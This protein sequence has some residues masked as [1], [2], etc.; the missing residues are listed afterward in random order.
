M[1][2]DVDVAVAELTQSVA[3]W[4]HVGAPHEAAVARTVLGDAHDRA[5]NDPCATLE[6]Q[7]AR[8]EFERLGSRLWLDAVETRL[9][10][11]AHP[12]ATDDLDHVAQPEDTGAN[13]FRCDGDVR[14]VTFDNE[15]V[16]LRDLKGMHYIARP[17]AEPDRELH[18]LDLV[19]AEEGAIPADVAGEDF[20]AVT[21]GGDAGFVLDDQARAAY[22]RRLDE[23]ERDIDEA[24]RMNDHE[25][26]ALAQADREYLVNELARATGLG[27]RGQCRV[28]IRTSPLECH[29]NDALFH[30]TD[31]RTPRSSR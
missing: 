3:M 4:A 30:R 24:T 20:D 16:L 31:Q 1:D 12:M 14:T 10:G 8:T 27:G 11:P 17:L 13:V 28:G 25:R 29:P 26:K 21:R 15:T 7:S 22:R 5:G 23:I 9:D 19:A 6:W 2:G 18:V